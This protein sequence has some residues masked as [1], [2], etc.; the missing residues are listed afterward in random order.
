MYCRHKGGRRGSGTCCRSGSWVDGRVELKGCCIE[1]IPFREGGFIGKEDALQRLK[2]EKLSLVSATD[3]RAC[4]LVASTSV[5]RIV[6]IGSIC[7]K[8]SAGISGK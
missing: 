1:D 7:K 5:F 2:G 6:N 8:L 3:P 4:S